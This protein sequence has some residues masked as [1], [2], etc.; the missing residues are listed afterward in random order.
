MRDTRRAANDSAGQPGPRD[1][2]HSGI[3]LGN[4]LE[5]RRGIEE[6]PRLAFRCRREENG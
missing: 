3:I 1:P 4:N 6:E 5:P 2:D